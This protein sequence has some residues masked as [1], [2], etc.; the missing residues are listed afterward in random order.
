[1]TSF[2]PL[3][4]H[5]KF[6]DDH[7]HAFRMDKRSRGQA[8]LDAVFAHL[9][10]RGEREHFG[11]VFA[12]NGGGPLASCH[13]PDVMRWLDGNKP[14]R[15]QLRSGASS[16]AIG[17]KINTPSGE[18]VGSPSPVANNGGNNA[19]LLYFRVK[20]YV[21]DPSRLHEEFARYHLYLQVRKDLREGRLSAP[22]SAACLLA[23]Y[24]V[25]SAAGD[26]DLGER[27]KEAKAG[28][29]PDLHGAIRVEMPS[30]AL[31]ALS[32]ASQRAGPLT[33]GRGRVAVEEMALRAVKQ[34]PE[35]VAEEALDRVLV[36]YELHTSPSPSF[37]RRRAPASLGACRSSRWP[38]S[39][40]RPRA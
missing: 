16:L 40:R 7:C 19:P 26:F 1:M 28:F 11:L 30:E 15:K 9:D 36:H 13:S 32:A 2:W 3:Q 4:V 27:E 25:Q 20:F 10:L 33:G 39:R 35:E 17:A 14:L 12:E 22:S 23:S 37:P 31:C 24:A 18:N 5:V 38:R 34:S 6:L 21:T 29:F 8:L